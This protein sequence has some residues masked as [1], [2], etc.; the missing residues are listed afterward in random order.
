MTELLSRGAAP[1]ATTPPAAPWI[2][3]IDGVL[4][5][6]G[7]EDVTH[8]VRSFTF[9]P[10]GSARLVFQPGQYLTLTFRVDGVPVERCYTIASPPS[11]PDR[12]TI[13]VKRVP[14]GPV[15]NWLHDRMRVGDRVAATGPFGEFSFAQHPARRYAF[16]SAGSGIT[17]LMS[18]TRAL[19][20][21][22]SP[23]EPGGSSDVVFVHSARSPADII[24]RDEL[25]AIDARAD[26]SVAVV[27]EGDAPGD[28]WGGARGRLS[29][30]LLTSLVPDL[31]DREIFTCGPPA[32]MDAVR[33][34]LD[35]QGIDPSRRHE[36]SFRLGALTRAADD[37]AGTGQRHRVEFRGSGRTIE[38]AGES[39]LLDAAAE[40]GLVLPSSCGEGVCGTCKVALLDGRVDLQHAGGIRPREIAQGQILL[41]CS[42]PLDDLVIEA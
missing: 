42:R 26:M 29:L 15:S 13:T 16:L 25:V 28:R 11:R 9:R 27:C 19:C 6:T 14:G 23:H 8:D 21:A 30:P 12:L 1:D 36:E 5:C 33:A 38:C 7:I 37:L 32:Y 2:D 17:P 31:G 20:E 18:M 35:E 24:F 4:T 34:L 41:C 10:P 3:E 22:G 39:T 40:A